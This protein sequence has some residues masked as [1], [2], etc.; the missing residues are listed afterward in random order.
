MKPCSPKPRV[1]RIFHCAMSLRCF[2]ALWMILALTSVF[3][4]QEEGAEDDMPESAT[5][6]FSP[7]NEAQRKELIAW[8]RKEYAKPAQEWPKA[9]LD[10][11]RPKEEIGPVQWTPT[12]TKE[13]R[14]LGLS[15]FFEPRLSKSMSVSCASCHEPQLGWSNGVAF[16]FGEHREQI[17]RHPPTLVGVGFHKKLFWDGRTD[18][19]EHQA[20]DVIVHPV[21][22]NG[23]PTQIAERLNA[24][25]EYY[26]P[27]FKAAFGDS[28]I[29]FD[30]IIEA[31]AIFERG[32][33]AGRT[34]FDK[35]A[36][37]DTAIFSDSEIAGLHLFRTKA[38][39]M[40]CHMGPMFTDGE[41][42]NLGLTY[43]GRRLQDMGRYT[44]TGL[45]EDVGKFRTPTLRNVGRTA[46]YMHN[47]VFPI[48]EG[49]LRLYNA[50]MPHPKPKENQIGDPLFPKTSEHL[51][52]LNLSAQELSDLKDFL[53][54]LNEPPIRILTPPVPPVRRAKVDAASQKIE[55]E[56]ASPAVMR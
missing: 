24:E 27:L 9:E 55:T 12:G 36:K 7:E 46:P 2:G 29:S 53:L 23:D 48:L 20:R 17:T 45:P 34:K 44:Q 22:M 32:I 40:N 52:P 19:L 51:K 28:K 15:L 13:Q 33:Q 54:T 6:A 49:V 18:S 21:E 35:F 8:L 50:G 31:L 38:R 47:G 56:A 16:S 25:K 14:R 39:C 41:F 4:Q 1:F 43:Y 10:E 30:R 3:A 42:H 11:G 5:V 37:G 26:G